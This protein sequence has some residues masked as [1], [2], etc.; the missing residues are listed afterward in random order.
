MT[1]RRTGASGGDPDLGSGGDEA[2][3]QLRGATM[4]PW[5]YV[6]VVHPAKPESATDVREV[7][8]G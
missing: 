3:P 8:I 4:G 6:L 2:K 7:L 1:I 5:A